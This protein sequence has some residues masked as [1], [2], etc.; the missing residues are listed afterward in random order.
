MN[1]TTL[2]TIG[3]DGVIIKKTNT[4]SGG[5][6]SDSVRY[7]K[8]PIGLWVEVGASFPI[9]LPIKSSNGEWAILPAIKGF[10]GTTSIGSIDNGNTIIK[11]YGGEADVRDSES[12]SETGAMLSFAQYVDFIKTKGPEFGITEEYTE[13]TEDEFY[14]LFEQIKNADVEN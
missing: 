12:L 1:I 10:D 4:P 7:Y 3:L 6:A 2:N 11:V 14:T 13:I 9:M 5:G 8:G